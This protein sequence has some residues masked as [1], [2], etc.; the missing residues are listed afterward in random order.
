LKGIKI[1]RWVVTF[2][3]ND[4]SS[5]KIPSCNLKYEFIPPVRKTNAVK[6]IKLRNPLIRT[7]LTINCLSKSNFLPDLLRKNKTRKMGRI[8]KSKEGTD[9]SMK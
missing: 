2:H 5:R 7:N 6:I 8:R 1:L 3:V 4:R 9:C